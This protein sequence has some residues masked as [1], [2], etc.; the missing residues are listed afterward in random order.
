[1]KD[2]D[3]EEVHQ[4]RE[5]LRQFEKIARTVSVTQAKLRESFAPPPVAECMERVLVPRAKTA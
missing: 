1:M 5:T 2:Y 3:P 4:M